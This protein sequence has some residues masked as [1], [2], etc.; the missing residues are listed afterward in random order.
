MTIW[1]WYGGSV[2]QSRCDITAPS[3]A[4]VSTQQAM[5]LDQAVV[6]GGEVV[7]ASSS[8]F[9]LLVVAAHCARWPARGRPDRAEIGFSSSVCS[10]N[11][12]QFVHAP[13]ESRTFAS[14]AA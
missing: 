11:G 10:M 8:A 13:L 3:R 14:C 1:S 5:P 4:A 2:P 6:G 9:V 7:A 12:D